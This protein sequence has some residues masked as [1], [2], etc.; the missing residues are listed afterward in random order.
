MGKE[1]NSFKKE[2]KLWKI[3]IP[4]HVILILI[5]IDSIL[6]PFLESRM[7][8]ESYYFY[9]ILRNIC[10]Q[11]P[12]R[13]FW[14]FGSNIG[15]CSRCFGIFL[16]IFLIGIYLGIRTNSKIY[17]KISIALMLPIMID[18]IAQLHGLRQ[19]NN[20][21]RFITGFLGGVGA[22]MIVF[23]VYFKLI[24]WLKK[25]LIKGGDRR[26]IKKKSFDIN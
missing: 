26:L 7:V 13:C 21:L 11:L 20:F 18:G 10:H 12:S 2:I 24:I 23:P 1:I 5:L 9:S 17:W 6:A 3:A 8:S 4:I 16:G 14:I 15:L 25:I 19:S 22:G